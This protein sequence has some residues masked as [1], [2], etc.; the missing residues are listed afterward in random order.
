[1]GFYGEYWRVVTN[2]IL[3]R[4]GEI[5]ANVEKRWYGTTDGELTDLGHQQ[6]AKMGLVVSKKYP[7]ISSIYSSPLKRTVKTAEALGQHLSKAPVAHPDLIEYGIGDLEGVHYETLA[8]EHAFFN[9][10][11][12][13]QDYAPANGE[14]VNQVRDRML[15]AVNEI[16][17]NHIGE[18]VAVV[19]HGAAFGIL[20][21]TLMNGNCFP[22]F[23]FHMSNTGYSHLQ[24]GDS[25]N[26]VYFNDD[27]H[28]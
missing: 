22:F 7:D 6:A 21:A 20:L 2:L 12:E 26:L 18:T 9:R 19:G 15:N 5:T 1:M 11:A 17:S 3:I 4:H 27:Q 16:A 24:I 14:S 10:I 28:L 23:D 25:P 8:T 13:N